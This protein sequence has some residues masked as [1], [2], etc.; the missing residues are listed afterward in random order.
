[1]IVAINHITLSQKD[2]MPKKDVFFFKFSTFSECGKNR[3]VPNRKNVI[4]ENQRL[5]N[6][7]ETVK[8]LTKVCVW[9]TD[10]LDQSFPSFYHFLS[11]E[12]HS[13]KFHVLSMFL[14][15]RV[16]PYK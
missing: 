5:C 7:T 16:L 9:Q 10:S 1:M 11:S 12:I 3:E 2:E 14:P 15:G 8:K 6:R 13:A 4:S